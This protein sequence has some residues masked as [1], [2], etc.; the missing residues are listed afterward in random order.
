VSP[1]KLVPGSLEEFSETL[2]RAVTR[3]RPEGSV[4]AQDARQLL[5]AIR[6]AGGGLRN[7]LADPEEVLGEFDALPEVAR[8]ELVRVLDEDGRW[9]MAAYDLGAWQPAVARVL[10]TA[11]GKMAHGRIARRVL[12]SL[13][14]GIQ[15]APYFAL[16]AGRGA[17]L[18]A[19]ARVGGGR[20]LDEVL[21]AAGVEVRNLGVRYARGLAQSRSYPGFWHDR[22]R[23]TTV[24]MIV[25]L[26][27]ID[28]EKGFWFIEGNMDCGLL[29]ERT[30]IYREDPFVHSLVEVA[31]TGGYRRLDFVAGNSSIEPQM[32]R[33]F[34]AGAAA[35]KIRV[36]LI[37]DAFH[38]RFGHERCVRV[39]APVE[40]G[41][42]VVRNRHYRT[43]VDY[44]VQHK[45]AS[46]RALRFYQ[47][48]SGD[49]SFLLP[50]MQADPAPFLGPVDPVDPYPN[51]VF[52][53]PERDKGEGVFFVK[54]ASVAQ[55]REALAET[56]RTARGGSMMSRLYARLDDQDGLF[57]PYIRT[58]ML[59]DRRLY[60]TRAHVLL[61]PA[62]VHFLS[63]HRIIG[64]KPLPE[65]LP[66]GVVPDQEP[67]VISYQG[68]AKF[69]VVPPEAEGAVREAALGVARGLARALELTFETGPVRPGDAGLSG[70]R[71]AAESNGR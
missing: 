66:P 31:A 33:Q 29:P 49:R 7:T 65:E 25:G 3:L 35:R 43:N 15:A 40:A 50:P 22:A 17:A 23:H 56:L 53:Y 4:S 69:A 24:G 62:G 21:A 64:S 61:T 60:R 54:A 32:A 52:K 37:E 70:D 6:A 55:A 13:A 58:P 26:D 67:Y 45:R 28:N 38:P 71:I 36:S 12:E 8:R 9:R 39:P 68:E 59:P 1:E 2:G 11:G 10:W 41:V 47:E 5:R 44:V 48:E 30:A 14:S 34:R 63:A 20:R 18:A 16:H 46:A 57:Q 19:K 42:L 27:F 51:L